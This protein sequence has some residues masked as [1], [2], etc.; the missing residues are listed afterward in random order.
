MAECGTLAGVAA[1]YR[2]KEKTC[3][4]CRHVGNR[5]Q[6]D[7]YARIRHG[8]AKT[9]GAPAPPVSVK[10][11]TEAASRGTLRSVPLLTRSS[12][13]LCLG[14]PATGRALC[15][16][17]GSRASAQDRVNAE[18]IHP[19]CLTVLWGPPRRPDSDPY[20]PVLPRQTRR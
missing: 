10:T 19:A 1:H 16:L 4:A 3:A 14:D 18:A 17:A 15:G 7:R 5:A 11:L 2:R 9:N 20:N 13:A 12:P 6:R 8:S